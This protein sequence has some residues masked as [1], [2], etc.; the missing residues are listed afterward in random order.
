M[1][2]KE[3]SHYL[4]KYVAGQLQPRLSS[5]YHGTPGVKMME[6]KVQ[7]QFMGNS[8]RYRIFTYLIPD[9]GK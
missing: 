9:I 5:E 4:L 3:E 2:L 1:L 6:C 7:R 8:F